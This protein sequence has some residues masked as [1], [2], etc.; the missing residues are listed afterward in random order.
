MKDQ[1]L[2]EAGWLDKTAG[3]LSPLAESPFY[4]HEKALWKR[5]M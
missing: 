1:F 5:G 2:E 4:K 3:K